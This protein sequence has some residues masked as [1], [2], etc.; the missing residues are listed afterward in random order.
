MIL[1]SVV[2]A[3][4]AIRLRKVL[5][6]RQGGWNAT[7][8]A[9]GAFVLIVAAVQLVLP[10]VD[11]VPRDFPADVLWSF[12]IAS[13]GTQVMLWA[14]IGLLFGS[15]T[16]RGVRAVPATGPRPPGRS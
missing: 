15:L 6:P 7:L 14:T 1:S 10:T 3:L 2:A 11:E 5:L 12:R 4:L 9:G 13:L 8:L 16:E